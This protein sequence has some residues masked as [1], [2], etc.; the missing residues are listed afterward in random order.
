MPGDGLS[1]CSPSR[2]LSGLR[3]GCLFEG[4][5]R[6]TSGCRRRLC[7]PVPSV[8]CAG[9]A[10]GRWDADSP[11]PSEM[12]IP[13]AGAAYGPG[14]SWGAQ[15][16]DRSPKPGPQQQLHPGLE[17]VTKSPFLQRATALGTDMACL[18]TAWLGDPGQ[19]LHLSEP[20]HPPLRTRQKAGLY[21]RVPGAS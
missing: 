15:N 19:L 3:V 16:W 1:V 12:C 18:I 11:P 2:E 7:A 6:N 14:E 5:T 10:G 8:H 20:P 4:V 13:P 21:H 9:E 17:R